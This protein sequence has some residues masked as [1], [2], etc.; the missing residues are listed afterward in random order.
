MSGFGGAN[1]AQ[2]ESMSGSGVPHFLKEGGVVGSEGVENLGGMDA[3]V[4]EDE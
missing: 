2:E 1:N 4:D 3:G